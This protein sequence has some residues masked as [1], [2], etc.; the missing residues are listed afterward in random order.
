MIIFELNNTELITL[1]FILAIIELKH[2][3]IN[4]RTVNGRLMTLPYNKRIMTYECVKIF[5]P[6]PQGSKHVLRF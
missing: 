4:A 6:H 5:L 3:D 1:Q 2:V